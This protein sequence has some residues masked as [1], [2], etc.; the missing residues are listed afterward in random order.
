MLNKMASRP[1]M[2][3]AAL[4]IFPTSTD[5]FDGLS[6]TVTS[7]HVTAFGLTSLADTRVDC[8]V[9]DAATTSEVV[10]LW[11]FLIDVELQLK[12]RLR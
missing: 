2:V 12:Q 10:I 1:Q 5:L 6:P 11:L 9:A 3:R 4:T 7:F 8:H